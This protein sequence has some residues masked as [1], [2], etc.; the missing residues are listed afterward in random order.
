M[1][2]PDPTHSGPGSGI[3]RGVAAALAA[4][5]CIARLPGRTYVW[6]GIYLALAAGLLS[7]VGYELIEHKEDLRQ[8]VL[9]YLFPESWHFAARLLIDKFLASQQ[10]SVL[11]N[12]AVGGSL[13]M[14]SLLLFPVKEAVSASY[15]TRANLTGRPIEELPL[16]LQGWEEVKLALLY[17]AAQGIIFW[18]GYYPG[19]EILSVV[20]SYAFLFSSFALDFLSP[21]FQRHRGR[22]SR[23]VKTLA[24]HPLT[25]LLFGAMFAMPAV[26]AGHI[27]RPGEAPEPGAIR[28][29]IIALFAV[30]VVSIAWAAVAGTRLA[31]TMM[32]T[33][34]GTKDASV[35][36]KGLAWAV[37]LGA[38]TF[39]LYTFGSLGRALHH[40]SQI[41]KCNY[42]V[43]W[44]SVGFDMPS[45]GSLLSDEVTVGVHFDVEIENP[46]PFDVVIEDNRLDVTH[47]GDKV[48]ETRLSPMTVPAGESVTQTIEFDLSVSPAALRKGRELLSRERWKMTLY[49]QVAERFEFPVFL[50]K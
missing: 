15:E 14:V 24:R 25:T 7:L 48:A 35:P 29:A 37:L 38:L 9:D 6:L 44:T 8:L 23:I 45:L 33:F 28:N 18:I 40:K 13:L 16:W 50:L 10:I 17:L 43:A 32:D 42:D 49:F 5:S 46:T 30:N 12:A 39:N 11:I 4:P 36:V 20:L 22:Y 2:E 41:L 31:S 34:E 27:F 21:V 26:I 19:N 3:G 1:S 47:E